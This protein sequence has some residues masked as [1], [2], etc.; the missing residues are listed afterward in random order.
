MSTAILFSSL[1]VGLRARM[2]CILP[3]RLSFF[4]SVTGRGSGSASPF[5]RT[6]H[7][8]SRQ[9]NQLSEKFFCQSFGKKYI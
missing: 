6:H 8:H 1:Q 3:L 5:A 7:E 2:A 9:L 4:R